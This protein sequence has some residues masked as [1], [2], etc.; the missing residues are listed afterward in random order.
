MSTLNSRLKLSILNRKKNH[1]LIQKG[2]TLV[3]LMI[4]IVIVGVLSSVALPNFLGTKS[5][6]EAGAMSGSLVGLA[7]ECSTNAIL[8]STTTVTASS[9]TGIVFVEASSN[10]ECA[11]GAVMSNLQALD[12]AKLSGTPCLKEIHDGVTGTGGFC[13][14]TVS[15]DGEITGAWETAVAA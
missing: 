9:S 3:E 7:K 4:V 6:A 13:H 2:F 11:D 5:K 12:I 14:I 1:N 8:D 15:A 10:K